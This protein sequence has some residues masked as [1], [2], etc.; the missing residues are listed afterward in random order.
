MTRRGRIVVLGVAMTLI[1][2]IGMGGAASA[3]STTSLLL[4]QSMAFSVLGH[5]CGGIQEDAYATGFDATTGYPTGDVYLQ[6]RCGGSGRGGGYQTTTYSAWVSVSWDFTGA[7]ISSSVPAGAP[8]VDPT[9]SSSDANGNELYNASNSAYL[10]LGPNF[11][12]APRVTGISSTSG[13]AA[14]GTSV[15]ITGTGFTG[16]TGVSFGATAAASFAINSDNSIT[17]VSPAAGAGTVDVLVTTAGG[18]SAPV[19]GDQFTFVAAPSVSGLSPDN[20]PVGGGTT[21]TITGANFTDASIVD[22]G[23]NAVGFTIND[24][25]SITVV[26]AAAEEP[27][28]VD[29]TVT[30]PGGTSPK[31]AADRF[32]FDPAGPTAAPSPASGPVGTA[33]TVTGGGFGPGETVKVS[34]L[35]G[36]HPPHPASVAL[37]KAKAA[38]DGTFSCTGT[39]SAKAGSPGDHSIVAKGKTS[40]TSATTVFTET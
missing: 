21:V 35:T 37:C 8:S 5:S 19:A 23:G 15:T 27:D 9:F 1:G 7:V 29:V 26:T 36:L 22:F 2:T 30:T 17:A 18:P 16:A 11:V 12:P 3:A 33:V 10:T 25:S 34:Y 14:G 32:T 40:A 4:P 13:P 38:D 24:D 39:I 20:G 28:T 6:T 31:G